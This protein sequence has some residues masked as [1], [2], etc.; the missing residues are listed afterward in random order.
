M[1]RVRDISPV[2]VTEQLAPGLLRA[3]RMPPLSAEQMTEA[4]RA[5]AAQ[6]A[7]GPR[8]GVHGP[9]V[10]LLRSP[11]LMETLQRVGEY[12]RF[13]S[14]LPAKL[15]ELAVLMTARRW[16]QHFEWTV[17]VP[18]AIQA[19]LSQETVEALAD[20]RRPISMADDETTTYDF[21]D[22]LLRTHGVSEVTYQRASKALGDQR[23]IDLVAVVGYFTTVS[24]VM[25]VAHTPPP[26]NADVVP[27]PS[28][29][30]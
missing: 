9:F 7:S 14:P 1:N 2:A 5:A 12:L 10:P 27:L 20:G 18:L 6:L 29:P 26:P 3:E 16:T 11:Q 4:Q 21:C 30:L 15:I 25:N 28:L 19:G 13:Q 8:G 23:L 24:M 17:H 22:E